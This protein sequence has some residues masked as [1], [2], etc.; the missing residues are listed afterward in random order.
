[1]ASAMVNITASVLDWVSLAFD[2]PTKAVVFGVPI[3]GNFSSYNL[4][5]SVIIKPWSFERVQN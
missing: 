5:N 2:A 4:P 3:D 1:M